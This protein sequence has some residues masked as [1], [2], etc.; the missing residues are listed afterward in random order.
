[1]SVFVC[2][3][4]PWAFRRIKKFQNEGKQSWSWLMAQD[5]TKKQETWEM[6]WYPDAKAVVRWV[7]EPQ[8]DGKTKHKIGYVIRDIDPV[9]SADNRYWMLSGR[10]QKFYEEQERLFNAEL[11]KQQALAAFAADEKAT[12]AAEKERIR[13]EEMEIDAFLRKELWAKT[14]SDAKEAGFD[15]AYMFR[16][17][18]CT[19]K[20]CWG[21][22]RNPRQG[23]GKMD[24]VYN[25]K[26]VPGSASYEAFQQAASA[27]FK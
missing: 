16:Y 11:E 19:K 24:R 3:P 9:K 22:K 4:P 5:G 14:C 2:P 17:G 23:R 20:E 6:V 12:L 10:Y 18:K 26:A 27:L 8:P 7:Q 25:P 15:C 1:M 21:C 13:S